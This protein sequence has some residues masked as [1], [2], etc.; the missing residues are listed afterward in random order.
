MTQEF[1][2]T[3][4]NELPIDYATRLQEWKRSYLNPLKEQFEQVGIFSALTQDL[5][6]AKY[7]SVGPVTDALP[8]LDLV[9]VEDSPVI[10]RKFRTIEGTDGTKTLF[11]SVNN[12]MQQKLHQYTGEIQI[13]DPDKPPIAKIYLLNTDVTISLPNKQP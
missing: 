11:F 8:E 5:T 6:S 3:P 9:I 2:D 1:T 12:R 4:S 10:T 13:L 7:Y